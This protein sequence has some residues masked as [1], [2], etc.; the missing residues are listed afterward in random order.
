M[1]MQLL[2]RTKGNS[3][4]GAMVGAFEGRKD[5]DTLIKASVQLLRK[6]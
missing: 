1:E 5:Y 3:Y 6:E 2:G 4:I